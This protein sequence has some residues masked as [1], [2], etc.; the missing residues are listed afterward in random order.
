MIPQRHK[1]ILDI[2]SNSFHFVVYKIESAT[3]FTTIFRKRIVNRL[4]LQKKDGI[5]FLSEEDFA[6]TVKI[7]FG[8]KEIAS[9]YSCSI[10]ATATSA[11]REA[12]NNDAFIEHIQKTTGIHIELL[13]GER[14]ASLIYKAVIANYK[15]VISKSIL[16]LDIGGGSTECILGENRKMLFVESMKLGAVRLANQFFP[17]GELAQEKIEACRGSI[18][19]VI[20]P[21]MERLISA[22]IDFVTGN[23]GTIYAVKALAIANN[24][25][26]NLRSQTEKILTREELDKTVDLLLSYKTIEERKTIEGIEPDR[27]DILPA[28]ALI[29]QKIFYALNLSKLYLS[30]YSLREGKLLE[31]LEEA[32]SKS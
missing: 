7:I 27:A 10:I 17:G 21:V 29:L 1:A 22:K 3:T 24:L 25:N 26:F 9:Q 4:A 31:E 13:S 15:E 20:E 8:L 30:D 14:E 23:S 2:G 11:V 19:K 18:N 12:S 6:Q 16:S 28:G 5:S 32:E